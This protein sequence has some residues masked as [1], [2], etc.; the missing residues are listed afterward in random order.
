MYT[1]CSFY[2][3]GCWTIP[4]STIC[5]SSWMF[6]FGKDRGIL[7]THIKITT[8]SLIIQ[9][10]SIPS[11]LLTG[12]SDEPY[13]IPLSQEATVFKDNGTYVT[14]SQ[15][16]HL[17]L[18]MVRFFLGLFNH[19]TFGMAKVILTWVKN[20]R[21]TMSINIPKNPDPYHQEWNWKINIIISYHINGMSDFNMISV[22]LLVLRDN[23]GEPKTSIH[24][25]P[26]IRMA[27]QHQCEDRPA[28]KRK[29]SGCSF[30][31]T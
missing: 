8:T 4:V 7:R 19:M 30:T 25:C 20:K 29:H 26:E 21:Y 5:W 22:I 10:T 6:I 12:I 3:V 27:H 18:D 31:T 17:D 13:V 9:P 15:K 14:S 11:Q 1:C 16:V 24:T 23:P 2:I 28:F